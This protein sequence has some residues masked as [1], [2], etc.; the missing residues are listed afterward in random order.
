MYW[1]E[2]LTT[3]AQELLAAGFRVLVPVSGLELRYLFAVNENGIGY[4]QVDDLTKNWHFSSN[5]KPSREHG[6]GRR[7]YDDVTELTVDMMRDACNRKPPE[8]KYRYRN[9]AEFLTERRSLQ[10]TEIHL[11]GKFQFLYTNR[12]TT[13]SVAAGTGPKTNLITLEWENGKLKVSRQFVSD[14]GNVSEPI[15][16][17]FDNTCH[18]RALSAYRV[19]RMVHW[20]C[21]GWDA[22]IPSDVPDLHAK[23][24]E[25]LKPAD[26]QD[27]KFAV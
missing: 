19:T 1:Q 25:Y 12:G 3:F 17:T 5:H 11:Q 4:V 27:Q 26:P 13:A 10:Y 18:D 20:G 8:E 14:N 15:D 21:C 16:S 23:I 24:A 6:T 2:Q 7:L 22:V 9:L